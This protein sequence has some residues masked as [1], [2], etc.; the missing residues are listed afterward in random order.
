MT[1]Q[2]GKVSAHGRLAEPPGRATCW[3]YGIKGCVPNYTDQ[4]L[5]MDGKLITAV[6]LRCDVTGG[7]QTRNVQIHNEPLT[8]RNPAFQNDLWEYRKSPWMSIT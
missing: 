7:V 5:E 2:G 4:G 8:M 3:R 1:I 6:T